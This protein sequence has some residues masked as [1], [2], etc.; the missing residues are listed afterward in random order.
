MGMILRFVVVDGYCHF[1]TS[2]SIK[3]MMILM[4][5]IMTRVKKSA[6]DQSFLR[7]MVAL[8][9]PDS[10]EEQAH[11]NDNHDTALTTRTKIAKLPS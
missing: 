11:N 3:E 5:M 4:V 10:H 7:T 9:F 8:V 2:V 6:I 1:R